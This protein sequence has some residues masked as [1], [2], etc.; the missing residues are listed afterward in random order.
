MLTTLSHLPLFHAIPTEALQE[1]SHVCVL[2]EL[3]KGEVLFAEG[4]PA[5]A[6]WVLVQGWVHL[7]KRAPDGVSVTIADVTP[8]EGLCGLSALGR[9]VY[10]AA[11][12]AAS[13]GRA[14]CVPSER[15]WQLL[16]CYPAFA[17]EVMLSCGARIRQLS[18]TA[19]LAH[20]SVDRRLA[21]VLLRLRGSVGPTIP[22][23]HH[24]LARLAG[25]RW[26]TSIR[27]LAGMR[28][29]GWVETARGRVRVRSLAALRRLAGVSNGY[30]RGRGP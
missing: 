1:L 19:S 5:D 24:E 8:V 14:V 21:Y 9:R 25:T 16:E 30:A 4:D 3:H 12:V 22:I 26:E 15:F 13:A 17:R 10:A 2:R 23:T 11:A 20:A 28:R 29:K 18:E 7:E 27:T 6:L